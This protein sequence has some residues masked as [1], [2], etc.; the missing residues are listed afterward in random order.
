MPAHFA[1]EFRHAVRIERLAEV[2]AGTPEMAFGH[3]QR[4]RPCIA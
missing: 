1:D 3:E 4:Q 2:F